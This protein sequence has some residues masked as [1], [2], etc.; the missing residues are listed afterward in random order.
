MALPTI[1][2]TGK[3]ILITGGTQGIG[4]GIAEQF[5]RAGAQLYLTYKWNTADS[6]EVIRSLEK[7]GAPTPMLIEA[8]AADSEQTKRALLAL[9]KKRKNWISL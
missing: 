3:D 6:D 8:D 4:Y 2:L 5:A 9:P 7:L 1:D